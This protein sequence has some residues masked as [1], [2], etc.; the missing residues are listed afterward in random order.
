V[1]G[2]RWPSS[3]IACLERLSSAKFRTWRKGLLQVGQ[4]LSFGLHF[5]QMLC[6][7]S[8]IVIGGTMH[9]KQTGHSNS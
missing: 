6:P 4:L 2:G 1:G 9:S 3:A 8:H 5:G 7:F